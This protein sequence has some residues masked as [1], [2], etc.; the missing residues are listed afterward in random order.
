[1]TWARP[2]STD[3]VTVIMMDKPLVSVVVPTFNRAYCIENT[4]NSA[5]SQTYDHLEL[6]IIDDGSYDRTE[7]LILSKFGA[8][9]RV[10]YVFK[11]NGGVSN[12]R[13]HGIQLAR[14]EFI[15]LLDS[16]DIWEPWKLEL[17]VAVMNHLPHVGMVWT[18]M[19]AID[20]NG[21]IRSPAYLRTMYGA[22]QWFPE[23]EDLFKNSLGIA[24]VAPQLTS[25]FPNQRVYFDDIFSPMLMGNL[26]HT[27]TVLLRR[28]IVEHVRG[29]R[30]DLRYAGE[31]YDFHLRTCREGAV[32]FINLSSIVYQ[33]GRGDQLTEKYGL[34]IAANFLNT[35]QPILKTDLGRITLPQKMIDNMLASAHRCLGEELIA[36]G[37]SGEAFRHFMASIYRRPFQPRTLGFAALSLLPH[38]LG[39]RFRQ[40]YRVLK[41]LALTTI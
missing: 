10:R 30:E 36:A 38:S 35:V 16:D 33:Y 32:A 20:P 31:D 3:E 34:H 22:Y 12:A 27:S 14:G 18:D 41:L 25:R 1:M 28:K 17:Q 19:A 7:E 29:F 5:L 37:K 23:P 8:D 21:E 13:N 26:V 24:S 39:E 9:P 40:L 2:V 11:P 15:A 6:I 4:I